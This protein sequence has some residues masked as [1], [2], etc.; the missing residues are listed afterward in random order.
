M[1]HRL[2]AAGF[3]DRQAVVALYGVSALGALAAVATARIARRH[4]RHRPARDRAGD[5]RRLPRP[6]RRRSRRGR[7]R[8][9][10][11]ASCVVMRSTGRGV[12]HR[13]GARSGRVLPRRLPPALRA[14]IRRRGAA[15][16]GLAAGVVATKMV[17]FAT[18][19][20]YQGLWRHAVSSPSCGWRRRWCSAA[21][22]RCSPS[23]PSSSSTATRAPC[24]SSMGSCCSCSWAAARCSPPAGEGLRPRPSVAGRS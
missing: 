15:V 9:A 19:R 4:H 23:L 6:G 21:C 3:S 16:R 7:R 11:D 24:S 20:T 10:P 13:S 5:R 2:V 17:A 18:L 8:R 22:S 12:C 14:D 1:S